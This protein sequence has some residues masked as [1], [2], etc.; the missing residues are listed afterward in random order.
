[1]SNAISIKGVERNRVRFVVI[2]I[3]ADSE[4]NLTVVSSNLIVTNSV[5]NS[6]IVARIRKFING[7]LKFICVKSCL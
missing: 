3:V 5:H 7:F 4:D 2:V 6:N 1:M